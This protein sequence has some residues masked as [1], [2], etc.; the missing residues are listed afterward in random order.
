MDKVYLIPQGLG[1]CQRKGSASFEGMRDEITP[2]RQRDWLE[3]RLP[4]LYLALALAVTTLLCFVT[5]PFFTPDEPNQSCRA[6]SLSHGEWLAHLGPEESGAEID[7][8]ALSAMDGMNDVRM[9]WEKTAGDF[10]N[11]RYGPIASAQERAQQQALEDIRWTHTLVFVPFGNTAVYPPLLYLPAAIG[12]RSGEA[13]GLTI[14]Q[15]LRLARLLCAWTAVGLGWLAL[16]LCRCSRWIL[17]VFLLLPSTSFLNASS[18]QDAVLLAVAALVAAMLSRPLIGR[19][20]F[21]GIELAATAGL[22]A[23]CATARPPY[24]AMGLLVFLPAVELE[25]KNWR[26]LLPPLGAFLCILTLC[27]LW[28]YL[29]TP[30]GIE[31]SDEADPAAQAAFLLH[32]PFAAGWAVLHG[33]VHAAGDF[34]WRGLY[35]IGWNDLVAPRVPGL[36]AAVG[37]AGIVLFAPA[38][39]L[40]TWRGWTL[41]T[42]CIVSALLGISAAEY[43]IWTPPGLNT[44]Y[45]VQPRYWLP[46]L[47]LAAMLLQGRIF[48]P[49]R[50]LVAGA[51]ILLALVACTLPGMA[52][53]AFYRE[54]VARVLRLNL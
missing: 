23:L 53:Q 33:T 26:G 6:I 38:C 32:H 21:T 28:R 42:V 18:S 49:R 25:W 1:P 7:S 48:A 5:A 44:V 34:V 35:V 22:I 50:S 2:D 31:W 15:S 39:P 20:E 47:P 41:L 24:M 3:R 27:A 45:G 8:G 52:A 43:V 9:Q 19:R 30:L 51:A 10:L 40:R 12:W 4:E 36:A 46:L 13:L 29:V 54:S 17:A 11:R 37:V 14:F 16:R